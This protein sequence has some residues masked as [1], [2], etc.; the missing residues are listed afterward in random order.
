[1]L[2][3]GESG[4]ELEREARTAR[5]TVEPSDGREDALP[6]AGEKGRHVAR[7]L[8]QHLG[9]ARHEPEVP[10]VHERD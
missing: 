9:D 5:R 3:L 6:G 7:G 4:Q 2:R 10:L 8:A 1:M